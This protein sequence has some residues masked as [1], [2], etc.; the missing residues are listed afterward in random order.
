M[1]KTPADLV[2]DA[3]GL[4]CPVPIIKATDAFRGMHSGAV[5]ELVSDDP[6]IEHD[7]PAWVRAHG[8]VLLDHKREGRVYRYW[9]EKAAD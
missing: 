1:S 7:L 2:V 6:A 9:V 8:H 3:T 5:I 4:F